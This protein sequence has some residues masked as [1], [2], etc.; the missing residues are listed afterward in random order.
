M[1]IWKSSQEKQIRENHRLRRRL[2]GVVAALALVAAFGTYWTMH[3]NGISMADADTYCG[4][5]EHTH[6]S[7]CYAWVAP[8]DGEAVDSTEDAGCTDISDTTSDK[9]SYTSDD[10]AAS[11]KENQDATDNLATTSAQHTMDASESDTNSSSASSDEKDVSSLSTISAETKYMENDTADTSGDMESDIPHEGDVREDGCVYTLVCGMVEHTHTDLCYD[12]DAWVTADASGLYGG[13]TG[14]LAAAG[15]D[16]GLAGADGNESDPTDSGVAD[17]ADGI[18]GTEDGANDDGS[19]ATSGSGSSGNGISLANV[20]TTALEGDTN[21]Y[22]C[23]AVTLE[24]A[25]EGAGTGETYVVYTIIDGD[26]YLVDADGNLVKCEYKGQIGVDSLSQDDITAISSGLYCYEDADGNLAFKCA[27][28]SSADTFVNYKWELTGEDTD[29]DGDADAYTVQNPD[30]GN[31][32]T[33]DVSSVSDSLAQTG[34]KAYTTNV[35]LSGNGTVEFYITGAGRRSSVFYFGVT[36]SDVT[37]S[38]IDMYMVTSASDSTNTVSVHN[39]SFTDKVDGTYST[40]STGSFTLSNNDVLDI[41][42][43]RVGNDI[44]MNYYNVTTGETFLYIVSGINFDDEITANFYSVYGNFEIITKT[45]GETAGNSTSISGVFEQEEF[46]DNIDDTIQT[47]SGNFDV[48]YSFHNKSNMTD[49]T[50]NYYNFT[51][52]LVNGNGSYIDIRADNAGWTTGG[53][54]T[55]TFMTDTTNLDWDEWRSAMQD[56]LDCS[57]NVIR[58]G[59]TFLFTSCMGDDYTFVYYIIEPTFANH[60][61]T[62]YLKGEQCT[63]S[64]VSFSRNESFIYDSVSPSEKAVVLEADG[65]SGFQAIGYGYINETYYLLGQVLTDGIESG[66]DLA[67]I[68]WINPLPEIVTASTG[69]VADDFTTTGTTNSISGSAMVSTT[70]YFAQ[71]REYTAF[72]DVTDGGDGNYGSTA[73]TDAAFYTDASTT[74]VTG[75]RNGLSLSTYTDAAGNCYVD[76]PYATYRSAGVEQSH[77][78]LQGWYDIYGVNTA[79]DQVEDSGTFKKGDYYTSYGQY[80]DR[81]LWSN[82]TWQYGTVQLVGNTVFYADWE[83]SS[84]DIVD[85]ESDSE[86]LL[87]DS[88]SSTTSTADALGYGGGGVSTASFMTTYLFDYSDLFNLYSADLYADDTSLTKDAHSEKWYF[89]PWSANSLLG[90]QSLG[91]GFICST[92]EGSLPFPSRTLAG[93]STIT[94]I[95]QSHNDRT[96]NIIQT[97]QSQSAAAVETEG[98]NVVETGGID[99][100]KYLF[101]TGTESGEER[102]AGYDLK[103]GT[104]IMGKTYVGTADY[105]FQYNKKTG[106]YYYDAS[107][108]AAFYNQTDGRFYLYDYVSLTSATGTESDFIP[109]TYASMDDST[110]AAVAIN[111]WLGM[112]TQIDFD[113]ED[114]VGTVTNADMAES[115]DEYEYGNQALNGDMK[116][117]FIGDDDVWVY[118]DGY[119]ILDLGGIHGQVY[120]EVDFSSGLIT[121]L[122]DLDATYYYTSTTAAE[123]GASDPT[124]LTASDIKTTAPDTEHGEIDYGSVL[125]RKIFLTT[126]E[127][128]MYAIN[129]NLVMDLS[130]VLE[131]Y[132]MVE[133]NA[134]DDKGIYYLADADHGVSGLTAAEL[135]SV[136]AAG[137]HKL[138]LYYME[139]GAS[140]SNLAVYCN[141]SPTYD[142]E[143]TK[144]DAQTNTEL[145]NA[146]FTVYQCEDI[147]G[148]S[149]EDGQTLKEYLAQL[150]DDGTAKIFGTYYTNDEKNLEAN[151][152]EVDDGEDGSEGGSEPGSEGGSE[153]DSEIDTEK[154]ADG[155]DSKVTVYDLRLGYTYY[156]VESQS[157]VGYPESAKVLCVRMEL[158]GTW[159][160]EVLDDSGSVIE[161]YVISEDNDGNTILEVY[162]A[163]NVLQHTY[164]VDSEGNLTEN[165]SSVESSSSETTSLLYNN[166]VRID[167]Q[168][169]IF[170]LVLNI[171]NRQEY[172][173]PSTGGI[174]TGGFTKWGLLLTGIAL[175][176]L[177]A[178]WVAYGIRRRR[179]FYRARDGGT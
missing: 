91:L 145:N 135:A 96:K 12:M 87:A 10:N 36:L 162:D 147:S 71:V 62:M 92:T 153:S 110:A 11:S 76:L 179:L 174:G 89:V 117:V 56:G 43:V 101:S 137:S 15:E 58:C 69:S 80:T 66:V 60:D 148:Y 128:G 133:A 94:S 52:E 149:N 18:A 143:L 55:L 20:M 160:A 177:A 82:S 158:D 65:S 130:G 159:T 103:N 116:F 151:G 81:T 2:A 28:S 19:A 64:D 13:V 173:L 78:I 156:I 131:T 138:T 32:L 125:G 102:Y 167:Y 106:Y 178:V 39:P 104:G 24:R 144:E 77:I 31:Y 38:S 120:G 86:G 29:D 49:T 111:Y 27:T 170:T 25:E 169:G 72:F 73:N 44:Y 176:L 88:D 164:Q 141:L 152:Y 51:L 118:V 16:P 109:F 35:T 90:T 136:E 134:D 26:Y 122:N 105:L 126:D 1:S 45:I 157:P 127:E 46:A 161:K 154:Y 83:V 48:T 54:G 132:T 47:I 67:E 8:E 165:G 22:Y 5:P 121:I 115:S 113:L 7:D 40:S 17:I 112:E 63:I 107:R 68:E 70:F 21:Y 139:R 3:L 119:P 93:N 33:P 171:L 37:G 100:L 95:N 155:N 123:T 175:A 97:I 166:G 163:N 129:M 41:V 50:L 85:A 150:A 61:V 14:L 99:I 79:L 59:N 124:E 42:V 30:S 6:T 172:V 140:Q 84:Y 168:D 74:P 9:D 98:L 108:N 34:S 53:E 57:I 4:L 114:A 146:V 75:T 23:D 142:M